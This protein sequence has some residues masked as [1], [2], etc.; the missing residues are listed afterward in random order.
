MLSSRLAVINLSHQLTGE[1]LQ[2]ALARINEWRGN[3]EAPGNCP[4]CGAPGVA[5]F[6]RSARPYAEWYELKCTACGLDATIQ[7]PM[8]GPNA[9]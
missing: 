1:K 7:I 2:E 8:P 9:F 4:V 6:D 5:I 3:S